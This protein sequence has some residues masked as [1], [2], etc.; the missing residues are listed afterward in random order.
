MDGKAQVDVEAYVRE[1]REQMESTLRQVVM[2][3]N[4]A[5]DGAWVNDSEMQVR[6]LMGDLRQAAYQKAVQMRMQAAEGA[7]SPGGPRQRAAV[8]KQRL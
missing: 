7:F 4:A 5:R 2:T 1:M 6:D 8:A 3:V